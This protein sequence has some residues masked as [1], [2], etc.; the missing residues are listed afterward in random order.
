[1]FLKNI[2]AVVGNMENEKEVLNFIAQIIK[3]Q[4]D[5]YDCSSKRVKLIFVHIFCIYLVVL[6]L[7]KYLYLI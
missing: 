3:A 6:I 5:L 1:M 2:I 4:V 7:N